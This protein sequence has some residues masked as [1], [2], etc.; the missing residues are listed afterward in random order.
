MTSIVY[1]IPNIKASNF[2]GEYNMADSIENK[3]DSFELKLKSLLDTYYKDGENPSDYLIKM[4]DYFK[5]K[6]NTENKDKLD[7][8]PYPDEL[9]PF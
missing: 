3:S 7:T 6:I 4:I 8:E 1:D 9:Y 5:E 2:F